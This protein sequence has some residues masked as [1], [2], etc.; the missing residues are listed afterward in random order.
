MLKSIYFAL[1]DFANLL[2]CFDAI[3]NI[4]EIKAGYLNGMTMCPSHQDVLDGKTGH[5]MA[6]KVR[7][8]ETLVSLKDLL[9]AFAK[10]VQEYKKG[11]H[12]ELPCYRIG[13]Y[14]DDILDGVDANMVFTEE[15]G[16]SHGI[17][18]LKCCN[19]FAAEPR[20]QKK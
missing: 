19:F 18:V 8:D 20:Y 17:E 16:P 13:C 5:F 7:Y 3:E 6:A 4:E 14:Y 1:G 12:E 2:H 10:A 9:H 15:F 11:N